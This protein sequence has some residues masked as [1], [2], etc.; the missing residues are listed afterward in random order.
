[1]SKPIKDAI[2]EFLRIAVLALIPIILIQ[3]QNGTID[4]KA[5]GIL[6]F[7]AILKAL[8]EYLHEKGKLTEN[9]SLIKGLTRF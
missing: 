4:W 6:S 1:M 8:D 2:L 7:T 5:L 3:L 9:E